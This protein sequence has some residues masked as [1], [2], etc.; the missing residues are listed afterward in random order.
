MRNLK[1]T[2]IDPSKIKTQKLLHPGYKNK[3]VSFRRFRLDWGF[4]LVTVW[5][6]KT[7]ACGLLE[8]YIR[9]PTADT[10]AADQTFRLWYKQQLMQMTA[11]WPHTLPHTNSLCN[12]TTSSFDLSHSP[13]WDGT[14]PVPLGGHE[15]AFLVCFHRVQEASQLPVP[16]TLWNS[17]MPESVSSG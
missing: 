7:E 9:A 14:K 6:C 17:G 1:K 10:W 2:H 4:C 11:Q 12:T 3:L 16:L 8:L 13:S 5:Q 15:S